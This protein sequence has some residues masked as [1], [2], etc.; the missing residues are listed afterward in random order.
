ML[1]YFGDVGCANNIILYCFIG[2][3]LHKMHVLMCRSVENN[4][5]PILAKYLLKLITVLYVSDNISK[6]PC[7]TDFSQLTIDFKDAI[8]STSQQNE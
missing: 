2:M 3:L 6:M 5:W 1:R 7:T 8:F 4:I